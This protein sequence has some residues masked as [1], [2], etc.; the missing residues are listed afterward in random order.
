MSP[1]YE[2]DHIYFTP[3]FDCKTIFEQIGT[4]YR[5]FRTKTVQKIKFK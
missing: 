2:E 3:E 5:R 1:R 4:I